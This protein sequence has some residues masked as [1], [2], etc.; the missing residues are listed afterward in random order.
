MIYNW[1]SVKTEGKKTSKISSNE[2]LHPFFTYNRVYQE[3][4]VLY[5][6]ISGF[7]II[8]STSF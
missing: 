6:D 4:K 1:R 2:Q 7:F 8:R 3:I 5:A